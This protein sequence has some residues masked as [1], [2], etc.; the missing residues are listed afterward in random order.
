MEKLK[1][2]KIAFIDI[3]GTLTNSKK[4]ISNE[5]IK[6]IKKAKEKGIDIVLCSGRTNKYVCEFS[7]KLFDSRYVISSNGAEIYDLNSNLDIYKNN[8]D[9]E[10]I[11]DIWQ[12][13]NNN[14][15]GCIVNT[16]DIRFCNSFLQN[17]TDSN[18]LE[19]KDV[20]ILK[21]KDIYQIVIDSNDYQKML[22]FK[23][24]IDE[25]NK[26]NAINIAKEFSNKELG[27]NY[28]FDIVNLKTSKGEA[29]KFLLKYLN[30]EKENA[31][32][33]GD[34]INDYEMFSECKVKVAMENAMQ[35][36]KD[37]ADYITLSNDKNG[38]SYFFEKYI[39]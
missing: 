14:S 27:R 12:Y 24:Y 5:T 7:E 30:L 3:D 15:I 22:E 1:N 33:F 8:I 11:K 16:K 32:C 6:S 17:I 2:I 21:D 28:F 29:I 23:K 10:I 9:F 37:K 19:I 35:E 4:I 39:I 20:D 13:S 34:S 31:I 38:I 18:K 25:N 26:I 36:L